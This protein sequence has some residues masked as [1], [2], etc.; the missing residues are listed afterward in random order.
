MI[1]NIV[2]QRP[3][4]HIKTGDYYNSS[5]EARFFL[6]EEFDFS[7][8]RF[9]NRDEISFAKSFKIKTSNKQSISTFL[10]QCDLK[11]DFI[12][13]F[14]YGEYETYCTL[15]HQIKESRGSFYIELDRIG[16]KSTRLSDNRYI[17]L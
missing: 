1:K 4:V 6:E 17:R 8:F 2:E 16:Y 13:S 14:I 3:I 9:A 12:R 5:F 10:K 11:G 7:E 15:N